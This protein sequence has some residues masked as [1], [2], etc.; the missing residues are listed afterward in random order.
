MNDSITIN[1]K[2]AKHLGIEVA[3]VYAHIECSVNEYIWRGDDDL[4]PC[5]VEIFVDKDFYDELYF[6]GERDVH[7]CLVE[8]EREGAIEI[9][10]ING[11]ASVN[12]SVRLRRDFFM[13]CDMERVGAI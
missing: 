7:D 8:L 1:R 6:M 13:N 11:C 3:A 2:L 10:Y 12:L 5:N 4:D 9:Q